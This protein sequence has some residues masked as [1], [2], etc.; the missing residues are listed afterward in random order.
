MTCLR[1]LRNGILLTAACWGLSG[2]NVRLAEAQQELLP[3][4]VP[5]V[6]DYASYLVNWDI[7]A[8]RIR[9]QT[10]FANIGDGLFQIRT[11]SAGSGTPTIP[12]WQRVFKGVDNGPLYTDYTIGSTLNFH[13]LHGH[14]H[15]DDF[16]EF[17]LLEAIISPEGVVT[18]GDLV[19]NEVKTSYRIT[20][21]APIPDSQYAGKISYPSSN[22]GLFQN[23][24]AGYGDVYSHGTEGQSI[25]LAGVPV[26]PSYW[27]RQI[28]D[29]TNVLR[30]KDETN[31]SIEILIDLNDVGQAVRHLNGT[32]VKP[33]DVAPPKP[34]DL[35]GNRIID[36]NDWL[37]FKAAAAASLTGVNDQV[38]MSL[39]DL[40]LDRTHSLSDLLLFRKYFD[41]AN[42]AGAFASLGQVPEP[43]TLLLCGGALGFFALRRRLLRSGR[44]GGRHSLAAGLTIVICLACGE[45]ADAR[46]PLYVQNFDSLTLGPNVDETAPVDSTAWTQT[47]PA[48]WS[49][50]DSG[51]P[52]VNDPSRG[53]AEWEGWSFAQKTWWSAAAEDQ[54]RSQFTLG[55]GNVAV[56]DPDEWDDKG[57]PIATTPFAG[58]YNARMSTGAIS[59]AGVAAG[60]AKLTFSSSWRAECCDEGPENTNNPTASIQASYD[61]GAF[62][63]VMRWE[64]DEDSAFYKP[65][66][67]NE[68]VVVNLNNPIGAGNVKL[69]FGLL[70]AANDWWWA[71]DNLEVFTPTVLEVD[72]QTGLMT[73]V[74]GNDLTG[75]EIKSPSGSLNTA[76]WLAGNFDAQNLG[77]TVRTRGDF[78][79]DSSVTSADLPVWNSAYG[80]GPEGDANSDGQTDGA[81]LLIW[82]REFG[83]TIEP[84]ESWET[85]FSGNKQLAEFFLKGDSS[86]ASKSIGLGYNTTLDAHDLSFS[87][88]SADGLQLTGI[89]RYLPT[90]PAVSASNM[91]PEP[92]LLPMSL[93]AVCGLARRRQQVSCRRLV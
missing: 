8:G 50:D 42:G 13:Q 16:S 85:V 22:T 51:V 55:Q 38:A 86:F 31:N 91:V 92:A 6:R 3:D 43:S 17:Q 12:L 93:A 4:I 53:V 14:I 44:D 63:E 90:P 88:T 20:D 87:Y 52:Y 29:P 70:N 78:N 15:F 47:P 61:G 10:M 82:Q 58:Y 5:W 21:S 60:A 40:D 76:G 83:N 79:G 23:I 39:G 27:L 66:A 49:V 73:I 33:G 74:G 36:I 67:T 56:A 69:K 37:A 9:F 54:G 71:I 89:V 25:S 80:V 62:V 81:D 45:Q 2:P 24:S 28:V 35:T 46:I 19:A 59:L 30:E 7:S 75:Y 18:V 11:Q 64:S 34:G 41:G 68:T 65:D 32:L 77:T 48:G 84:G 57:A 72:T 1:L 26:G